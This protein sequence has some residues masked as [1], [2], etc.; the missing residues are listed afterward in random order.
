MWVW[1]PYAPV[2]AG[3]AMVRVQTMKGM[4][5]MNTRLLTPSRRLTVVRTLTADGMGDSASAPNEAHTL[6]VV[7]NI[8]DDPV[9]RSPDS[10]A[11]THARA[12]MVFHR[13]RYRYR[14]Q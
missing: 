11:H 9:R 14:Y 13:S 5:R 6:N 4:D 8:P 7:R 12:R 10:T 3:C 2:R 1:V